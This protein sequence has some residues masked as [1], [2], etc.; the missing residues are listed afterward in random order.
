MVWGK[1]GVG[2]WGA[3]CRGG[4]DLY[5]KANNYRIATKCIY[6]Y[7]Y[8]HLYIYVVGGLERC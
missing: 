6:M 4:G 3:G 7:S 8:L 2:I 5:K 1:R